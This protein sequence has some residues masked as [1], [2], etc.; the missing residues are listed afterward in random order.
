MKIDYPTI[1]VPIP[2]LGLRPKYIHNKTRIKEILD[3][4]KRYS[5]QRFPIPIE[6]VEELKELI[7]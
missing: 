7:D 3:A 2:P 4:M 6:W 1:T 5:E